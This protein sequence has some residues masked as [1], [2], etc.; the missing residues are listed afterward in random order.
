MSS[1][2]DR[3]LHSTQ[4]EDEA[5]IEEYFDAA[6]DFIHEAIQAGRT[7]YVHCETG[8]SRSAAVV[9]AYRMKHNSDS[10]RVAYE[11]TKAKRG[12]I[13]PKPTFFAKLIQ[14][15]ARWTGRAEGS[16]PQSEYDLIYLKDHFA[17][18]SWLGIDAAAVE[19]AFH[20][21]GKAYVVAHA[22]LA[23]RVEARLAAT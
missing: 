7:A 16:F 22:A 17:A 6:A 15:E 8:K 10:L 4:D 9:L 21:A 19:D 1:R 3:V 12:Y 14:Q 13:Q 18:Y 5:P 20:E 2:Y 23:A 11:D